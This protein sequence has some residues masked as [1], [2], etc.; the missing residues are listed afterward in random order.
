MNQDRNIEVAYSGS[1]NTKVQNDQLS[2]VVILIALI[3]P[4]I[5]A[6]LYFL[7]ENVLKKKKN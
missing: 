6:V 3:V 1:A 2:L 5:L 7:S 4:I